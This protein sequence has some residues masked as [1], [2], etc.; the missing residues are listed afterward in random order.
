[1]FFFVKSYK[2]LSLVQSIILLCNMFDISWFLLGMEKL[3]EIVLCNLIGR[4]FMLEFYS[5]LSKSSK[6]LILYAILFLYQL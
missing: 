5:L 2:L 6:D 4:V 1:M 3:K